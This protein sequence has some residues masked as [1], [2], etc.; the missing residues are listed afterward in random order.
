[1]P[2]VRAFLADV[3]LEIALNYNV[4]GI[5]LD[6]IRYP[7]PSFGFEPQST[8][9]FFLKT[10]LNPMDMFRRYSENEELTDMWSLWKINQVTLTVETVRS[11]L[12]AE[13]PGVLLS[14]AV[15]ADPYEASSHYSCDWRSWLEAGLVDF[16]CTMAYTTNT[17][18]A[19]ELA[20]LGAA[21]CPERVIHGIGIYNQPMSSAF[22]G[23]SEALIRGCKGVCVFSL[24]SLSSDST[25]M[26]RNFWGEQGSTDFPIDSA[27]FQRVNTE[28]GGP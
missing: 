6:Y 27:V 15:M 19:R 24:N 10:G 25:W 21:V 20:V 2:E 23:A 13:V 9:A 18:K 12:R 17:Q 28:S 5:H 8:G 22:T 3:A 14:C 11:V 1:M 26:L 7:N 16:V 4:D